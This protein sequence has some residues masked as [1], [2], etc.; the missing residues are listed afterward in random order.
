[1]VIWGEDA[2]ARG[3]GHL[4][5]GRGKKTGTGTATCSSQKRKVVAFLTRLLE[6][7]KGLG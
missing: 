2:A 3:G 6:E 1:M 4:R 5:K 7:K